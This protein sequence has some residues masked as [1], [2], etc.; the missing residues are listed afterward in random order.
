[1][2]RAQSCD[3]VPRWTFGAN[4]IQLD[5]DVK[6]LREFLEALQG[7][8]L[9]ADHDVSSLEEA[10]PVPGKLSSC[11]LCDL[12][13]TCL[14]GHDSLRKERNNLLRVLVENEI[15]RLRVWANPS[16]ETA[17]GTDHPGTDLNNTPVRHLRCCSFM[18]LMLISRKHGPVSYTLHGERIQPWRFIWRNASRS[19][20]C[21]AKS[22]DWS[23]RILGQ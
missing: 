12:S 9:R 11:D 7:D 1:M 15:S 21:K 10:S 19:R 20:P 2:I 13:F 18:P 16:N 8:S 3:I 14:P 5:V 4:R 6:L 17:L 22:L 23:N